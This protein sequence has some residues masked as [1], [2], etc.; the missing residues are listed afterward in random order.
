MSDAPKT[1]YLRY[2]AQLRE[3]SQ[4]EQEERVTTA[5]TYGDLYQEL[6]TQYGFTLDL[7]HVKV[8]A[9]DTFVTLDQPLRA[10]DK[11]VFIPPVAGG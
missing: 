4:R 7:T 10:G 1:I 9:N 6:K 11:V 5:Q 3:Q 8:A 2:F